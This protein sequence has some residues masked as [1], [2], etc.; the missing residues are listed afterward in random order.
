MI[1]VYGG[2]RIAAGYAFDRPPVHERLLRPLAGR[3]RAV[4]ALDVG[5][6][7]GLSTAALAPY[8]DT[9]VGLE[10]VASMLAHRA[11]V[12]PGALFAVGTAERLPFGAE[13]FDLVT[14]AGC[15][16]YV[17]LDLFLPEVARVLAG[18]GRLYIYDFTEGRHAVGD[19]ALAD[20]FAR[21]EQ[22]FPWPGGYRPRLP[23]RGGPLSRYSARAARAS[24]L[25][26]YTVQSSMGTAPRDL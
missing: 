16:N 21:F 19:T 24:P 15:L 18:G 12:A 6:G 26:R 14:A 1:S 5:C 13:S 8:A 10:P 2:A 11:A 9:V 3:T 20:W 17:D 7:A 22:R 25:T 23:G 4:R